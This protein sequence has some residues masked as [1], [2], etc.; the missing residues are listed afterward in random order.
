MN[1][2]KGSFSVNRRISDGARY[3]C[4]SCIA[5]WGVGGIML[6][7]GAGVPNHELATQDLGQTFIGITLA[8]GLLDL[9]P[10]VSWFSH[11]LEPSKADLRLSS[12]HSLPPNLLNGF[13]CPPFY[14]E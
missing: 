9:R 4:P 3:S 12:A 7:K 13:H 14:S 6:L 8:N 11:S 2:P 10:A 5:G 1:G